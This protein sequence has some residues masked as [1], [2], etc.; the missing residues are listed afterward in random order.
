MALVDVDD[1]TGC[2]ILG[3]CELCIRLWGSRRGQGLVLPGRGRDGRCRGAPRRHEGDLYVVT[4]DSGMAGVLCL[5][6]CG[7]CCTRP[8]PAFGVLDA[9]TRVLE[10][11]EHL[12]IDVDQM[13][14]LAESGRA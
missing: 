9:V 4:A 1:T 3:E 14:V 11:C 2:P 8:L 10:H 13:A 7:E 5:T 12:G 6:L